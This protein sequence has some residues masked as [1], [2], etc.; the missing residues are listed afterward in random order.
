MLESPLDCKEIKPVNPKGNQ[1]WIFTGRTDAEALIHWPPDAKSRLIG[2]GPD[3]GKNWGQEKGAT[4]DEMIIQ[5]HR[6]KDIIWTSMGDSWRAGREARHAAVYGVTKNQTQ[7][8]N[9][10]TTNQLWARF[11]PQ[12]KTQYLREPWMCVTYTQGTLPPPTLIRRKPSSM[13]ELYTML[14]DGGKGNALI[15]SQFRGA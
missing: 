13:N 10:T 4:E 7:L 1:P 6:L 14:Q 5:H 3:A 2:K 11:Q 8:S 12:V 9:W 15:G